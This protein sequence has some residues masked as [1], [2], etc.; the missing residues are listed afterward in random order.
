M[1]QIILELEPVPKILAAWSWSQ[2]QCPKFEFQLHSPDNGNWSLLSA[3][4]VNEQHCCLPLLYRKPLEL[5]CSHF[6]FK[7][8]KGFVVYLNIIKES[9]KTWSS[10][11]E[12]LMDAVV[13]VF[14]P[15][16]FNLATSRC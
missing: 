4:P 7:P 16:C 14:V 3:A 1:D 12:L 15:P 2:G 6:T 5:H 11:G 10:T 9:N 13:S 8:I